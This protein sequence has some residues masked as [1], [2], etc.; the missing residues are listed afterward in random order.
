MAPPAFNSIFF[1][2]PPATAALLLSA[3]FG[4]TSAHALPR[5]TKVVEYH[6]LDVVP[7]PLPTAGPLSPFDL[8]RRQD[9]TVCGFIGGDPDLPATCSAGSHCVLD[10]PNSVVGCCP[11][12]GV[13][14]AGVFT[15]CVDR[16]S[17]PQTEINPYVFTCGGSDVCFKNQ[18][19]GGYSQFGCG[20]ASSLGTT[21]HASASGASTTLS[22]DSVEVS[23]TQTPS[24]LATPTTIGSTRSTSEHTSTKTTSHSSTKSTSSRASTTTPSTSSDP[25]SQTTSTTSSSQSPTSAPENN[26]H[27]R[28]SQTGAIV[29]GTIGGAAALLL[30][31]AALFF[32]W[33]RRSGNSRKGP[34]PSPAAAPT[35]YISPL[36]SHGAAFAPLP[37][38]NEDDGQFGHAPNPYGPL[39][40]TL[41][42]PRSTHPH[43]FSQPLRHNPAYGSAALAA[44]NGRGL[45]PVTEEE[46]PFETPEPQ[47]REI[48]DF[49]RAYSNAQ[50]GQLTDEYGNGDKTPLREDAQETG[51]SSEPEDSP[52]RPRG[53][54]R[55]LWQQN[56]QQSRNLMWL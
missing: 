48:D 35:Q 45:T 52:P 51:V 50:I 14:T 26:G 41:H 39:E 38:W 16:N 43:G 36:Q 20:T 22:I 29:G 56:R 1:R 25:A 44:H 18:F 6:V 2:L 4:L 12:G 10:A 34:G 31:A 9:D 46:H 17:D 47:G 28:K 7:F 49:S 8:Q 11:N 40:P 3:A 37:S 5:Q 23:L 27:L 19:A 13:C 30:L 32:C 24:S 54:H 21:V 42:A 55:P 33:R 53:G 15:G